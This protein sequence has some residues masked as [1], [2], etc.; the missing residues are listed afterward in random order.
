MASDGLPWKVG[1]TMKSWDWANDP[2]EYDEDKV[3]IP[4]ETVRDTY[5]EHVRRSTAYGKIPNPKSVTTVRNYVEYGIMPGDFLTGLFSNDLR[6]TFNRA[7]PTNRELIP[8][9][10]TWTHW[11]APSDLF[12]SKDKMVEHCRK[13]T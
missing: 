10:L 12:G 1:K 8:E 4:W 6:E 11:D 5:R 3:L 9:W 2:P 7:D 13:M